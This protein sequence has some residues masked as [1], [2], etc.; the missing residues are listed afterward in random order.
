[1]GDSLSETAALVIPSFS[2]LPSMQ[3]NR[4]DHR[5]IF[6]I[7]LLLHLLTVPGTQPPT[8]TL[9]FPVF[10]MV[11]EVTYNSVF[12]VIE[13]GRHLFYTTTTIKKA[14]SGVF[15]PEIEIGKG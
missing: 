3:G 2:P 11:D 15:I 9:L 14:V 12:G 6:K 13:H 4:Q 1:M 5:H 10:E 8:N 7:G